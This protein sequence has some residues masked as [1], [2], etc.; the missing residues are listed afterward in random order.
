MSF[1]KKA[2]HFIL[3]SCLKLSD[4]RFNLLLSPPD[5]NRRLYE[6]ALTPPGTYFVFSCILLSAVLL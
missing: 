2:L 4:L 3:I 6:L 1:F 5:L